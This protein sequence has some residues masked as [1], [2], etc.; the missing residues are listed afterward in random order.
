MV[1]TPVRS[2]GRPTAVVSGAAVVVGLAG[3]WLT[4]TAT[5]TAR[6]ASLGSGS[7]AAVS[8]RLVADVTPMVSVW[9]A[10][11]LGGDRAAAVPMARAGTRWPRPRSG[12]A[13]RVGRVR[14]LPVGR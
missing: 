11:G 2:W 13:R 6:P 3:A 9:P 10:A 8:V 1:S 14:V 4:P 12:T 5:D 7:A